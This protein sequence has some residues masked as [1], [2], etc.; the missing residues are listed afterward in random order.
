MSR[1][2]SQKAEGGKLKISVITVCRNAEATIEQ[3]L[4]SVASQDHDA[5]EYLVIDGGSTDRTLDILHD[6]AARITH[7]V[8]E[9]DEGLYDAMNKGLRLA[10][11]DYIGFLH[12]DDMFAASNV[13]S[14]IAA[15]ARTTGAD[16]L[17]GDVDM[18]KANDLSR[19]VRRYQARSFHVGRLRQGDMPPHPGLYIRREAY[20]AVGEYNLQ[21]RLSADFDFVVRLLHGHER[22]LSSM[23]FTVVKMRLGGASS[24]ARARWRMYKEVLRACQSNGLDSGYATVATKYYGKLKQLVVR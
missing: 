11:G 7:L 21:Y 17:S 12:A 13:L 8:S 15:A 6:H 4:D 24:G 20:R 5:V 14:R 18:V 9:P 16:V 23:D 3:T 1:P 19:V 2:Q 22:T 10:T